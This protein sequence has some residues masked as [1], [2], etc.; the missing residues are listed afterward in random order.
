MPDDEPDLTE[1]EIADLEREHEEQVRLLAELA[2]RYLRIHR[3]MP[4]GPSTE[5]RIAANM[6]ISRRQ[7]RR[8]LKRAL[9]KC[10]RRITQTPIQPQP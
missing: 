9:A 3:R 10:R 4:A 2:E 8:L 6:G 5:D 7:V 1:A